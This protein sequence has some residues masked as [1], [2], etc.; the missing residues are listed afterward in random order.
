MDIPA[1]RPPKVCSR[2]QP[3]T[4]TGTVTSRDAQ[5][6]YLVECWIGI[7]AKRVEWLRPQ[8]M[9]GATVGDDVEL[10]YVVTPRSG[11]WRVKGILGKV[12]S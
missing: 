6:F 1:G 5:G 10:V 11:L 9:A 2:H 3:K 7:G 12:G 4:M 8:D